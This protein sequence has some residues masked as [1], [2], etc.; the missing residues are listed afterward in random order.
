[1]KLSVKVISIL[2]VTAMLLC[3]SVF[4]VSAKTVTYRKGDADGDN[5]VTILDATTVQKRLA[6]L[7]GD[8]DGMLTIRGD[9]DGDGL[10]VLDA[11]YIQKYLAS[12]SIPYTDIDTIV[13]IEVTDPTQP[14]TSAT[15][16]T[17]QEGSY[18]YDEYELPFIP[19]K[20]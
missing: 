2:T 7:I 5:T 10:N 12:L 4:F 3:M 9:I 15:Q 18:P 13:S 20:P 8:P 6:T 1:M 11:T 14:A 16:A 17:S 19:N